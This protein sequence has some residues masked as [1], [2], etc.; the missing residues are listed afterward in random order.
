MEGVQRLE[1]DEEIQNVLPEP[2]P[3]RLHIVVE[4]PAPG[5]FTTA[6]YFIRLFR[7][8]LTDIAQGLEAL[9]TSDANEWDLKVLEQSQ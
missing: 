8:Y 9:E 4:R 2:W 1:A 6:T 3:K 7:L 5:Q